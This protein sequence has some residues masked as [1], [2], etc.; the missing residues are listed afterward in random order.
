V[1]DDEDLE[2][3]AEGYRAFVEEAAEE[4]PAYS[5]LAAAVADNHDVLRYLAALPA[6]KRQPAL[7]LAALRFLGGVPADGA[8]LRRRVAEDA[9]RLRATM[10][11][12]ATQT[13]EPARCTALL[14]LLATI[15]G[16]VALIEVGTSAGLCLYPDRY[17]YEYDG[18]PVG[19]RRPVHLY[20]A[21]SGDVPVPSRL[22]E[23]V[24]RVGVDLDP[25]DVADADQRAWLRTLVWPGPRE[26]E[27]LERLDAAAAVVAEDPPTLL[28]GD[29]VD[30]L[31]DALGFVP[32]GAIP[33]VMHTALLPYV[34]EKRRTAFV[35]RVRQ[36]PVRWLAQEAPG[37]VPGTGERRPGGW[38]NYFVL[39]LDGRPLA[40]TAPHGGRLDW[41]Q[42][43]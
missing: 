15:D 33:V 29:L 43:N 16:P 5:S 23:V 39:A 8:D 17:S 40:R 11:S 2:Q 20:C 21:T 42:E 24:A 18:R 12:R 35:E 26:A 31:D 38:G 6:D 1:T 36:L 22:P 7:F 4:S 30:R 14:P 9:E 19:Q 10:L 41:L 27:R 25:V 13:N 28:R 32:A 37:L 34:P 3:I